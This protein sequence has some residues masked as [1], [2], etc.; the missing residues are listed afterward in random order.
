MNPSDRP[1]P[2]LPALPFPEADGAGETGTGQGFIC[3]N[4][5]KSGDW[6]NWCPNCGARLVNQRCKF[7]CTRCTYFM[8]CSDFD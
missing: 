7:R 3:N 4:G 2:A 1:R 8:S 6:W 5:S